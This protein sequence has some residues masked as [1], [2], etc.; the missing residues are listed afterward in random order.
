[1]A[2]VRI[3]CCDICGAPLQHVDGRTGDKRSH[4]RKEALKVEIG[5]SR[6]GWGFRRDALDFSGEVCG[7]CFGA[8][9]P[10]LRAVRDLIRNRGGRKVDQAPLWEDQPSSEGRGASLRGLLRALPGR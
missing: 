4:T 7:E 5:Y 8:A 10:V 9:E 6:G 3:Q 1:M 2:D